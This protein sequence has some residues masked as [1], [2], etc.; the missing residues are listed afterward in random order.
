MK[1][2][3][4]LDPRQLAFI[5]LRRIRQGSFADQALDQVLHP[6][7]LKSAD[8]RLT[9]ELVYGTIRRQRTLDTIISHLTTKKTDQQPPDLQ[10]ILRLG[11]YQ[12][13]WL[14][15]VP[16]SAAV[17]TAVELAKRYQLGKLSGV[18][19]GVLRQYSRRVRVDYISNENKSSHLARIFSDLELNLPQDAEL[20]LGVLHSFPDWIIDVWLE[21]LSVDETKMLCE[22]FN[23]PPTIDLRINALVTSIQYVETA[24]QNAGIE[25]RGI[26]HLPSGLRLM[27]RPG[28]IQQLPGFQDGWW[29]IQDASAQLVGYLLDPHPGDL[30]VDACAAPG[31]KTTHIAEIMGDR[32]EVWGCDRNP[33]RLKKLIENV[34][35]LKLT[36]IR[37]LAHDSRHLQKF[38]GQADRVLVDV[39]CSGLG[40][41]HRHADARWRQTPDTVRELTQLQTDLLEQAST[42]IKP[43]GKLVYSTCTLHPAE[44]E[45]IIRSF[46]SQHP[47]WQIFQPAPTN[48]AAA[49]VESEGWIKVWPHRHWMDGFFMVC[50]QQS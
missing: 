19:N 36:S 29:M 20:Q 3:D 24:M 8:R 17:N 35:R 48:P 22:W 44:N 1:K 21:Q 7:S 34:K 49:F 45:A 42:W 37:V 14:N 15:H 13:I 11:L 38:I 32:G 46:L 40:T 27:D 39:P 50:L 5:A 28:N 25:T 12:L 43:G 16:P 23:R 18:V 41:L 26:A 30:V 4:P 47:G 6:V 33:S 31:G 10:I 9:T 2:K